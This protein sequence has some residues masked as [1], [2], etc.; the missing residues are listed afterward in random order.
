LD[1]LEMKEK[2]FT[3]KASAKLINI[4]LIVKRKDEYFIILRLN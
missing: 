3:F 2:A 4:T 1:A